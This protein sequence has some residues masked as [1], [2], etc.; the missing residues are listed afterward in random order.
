MY[1][2]IDL[3]NKKIISVEEYKILE[4]LEIS[5]ENIACLYCNHKVYL[6]ADKSKRKSHFSHFPKTSCSSFDFRKIYNL[7]S[8]YKKSKEEIEILKNDIILNSFKIYNRIV[9]IQN[10]VSIPD[11]LLLLSELICSRALFLTGTDVALIPYLCLHIREKNNNSFY[12]FTFDEIP[13]SP[14]WSLSS[15]KNV[16]KKF[17][18]ASNN[19]ILNTTLIPITSDFLNISFKIPYEFLIN[20]INPL[21]EIFNIKPP[22]DDLLTQKLISRVF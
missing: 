8:S 12:I 17:E 15:D 9:E 1:E 6:K 4:K 19:V 11:F 2:C 22:S 16:L 13:N 10:N 5:P 20:T 3:D 21:I 14:L 7:G 18:L